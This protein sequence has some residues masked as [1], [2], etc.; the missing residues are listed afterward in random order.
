MQTIF[1]DDGNTEG[2]QMFASSGGV[3]DLLFKDST[4][5]LNK[6]NTQTYLQ[7]LGDDY[8]G[9]I[10]GTVHIQIGLFKNYQL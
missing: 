1:G 2:F 6:I 4:I 8:A 10:E 5:R 7:F 9:T 3:S